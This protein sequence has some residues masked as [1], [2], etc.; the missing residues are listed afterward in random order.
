[1]KLGF[2]GLGR[3]GLRMGTNL[4]R[5]GHMTAFCVFS[6]T[7]ATISIGPPLAAWLLRTQAPLEPAPLANAMKQTPT[8]K[9]GRQ[10]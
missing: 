4:L 7:A 5:A 3:M 9:Y 1:V 6:R 8:T 2:I 10:T